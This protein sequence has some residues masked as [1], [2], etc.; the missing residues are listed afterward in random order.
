MS[1]PKIYR[2]LPQIGD[3]VSII[4]TD[5]K[6]DNSL[7]IILPDYGCEGLIPITAL[8]K[9]KKIRSIKKITK[10]G[11]IL[12]AIVESTNRNIIMVSRLHLNKSSPEYQ[13][14]ADQKRSSKVIKSLLQFFIKRGIDED[15]IL[16]TIVYPLVE[17]NDK[18]LN[19]FDYIK[20]NYNSLELEEELFELLDNYMRATNFVKK[21]DY[22]TRF[23]IAASESVSEMISIIR[24]IV[25]N[26]S[27]LKIVIED[28]PICVI[29]SNSNNSKP[30][31]HLNFLNDLDNIKNKNFQ[32][33]KNM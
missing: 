21:V 2:K 33:K 25:N 4:I 3:I 27:N 26:Y 1:N 31:D 14:W 20:N 8:T 9:K 32:L 5:Y 10:V 17:A 28:F 15:H 23:G 29:K 22:T 18:E 7:P 30:S 12:P 16:S 11:E 6:Q 19:D 13:K 24:P